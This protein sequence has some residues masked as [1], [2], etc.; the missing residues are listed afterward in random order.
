MASTP[1]AISS[2]TGTG[3]NTTGLYAGSDKSTGD[4]RR[5]FDFSDRFTE[6]SVNQTPFFRLVSQIAK[7][8]TDD[9]AFKYAE[10]RQSWHKRHSYV[11]AHNNGTSAD[12]YGEN[13]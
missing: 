12:N 2:V 9:P 6:L 5:R 10:K 13:S 3:E 7:S 4:L 1:L 8:P 11:I